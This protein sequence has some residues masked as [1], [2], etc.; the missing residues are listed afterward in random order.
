MGKFVLGF[1]TTLGFGLVLVAGNSIGVTCDSSLVAC[2]VNPNPSDNACCVATNGILVLAVQWLPGY[3]RAIKDRC[4][5]NLLH[6]IPKR[7]FTIHGLWP[8]NCSGFQ[9]SDCDP[10]RAYH[11]TAARIAESLIYDN[12]T[13]NWVSY[14]GDKESDYNEFWGHE[15][16]KHGTCYSLSDKK[17]V[18]NEKAADVEKFF[19]DALYL[20]SKYNVYNALENSQIIPSPTAIYKSEDIKNAITAEFGDLSIGLICKGPYLTEI[21]LGLIG[22]GGGDAKNGNIYLPSTCPRYGVVYA[23]EH[24]DHPVQQPLVVID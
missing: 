19:S 24:A 22:T 12:M 4:S 20:S 7:K 9:V 14:K 8:D 17:C 13:A 18:G 1:L 5:H 3:C 23:S 15:W 21:R 10:K 6:R 2:N 16:A 11:D